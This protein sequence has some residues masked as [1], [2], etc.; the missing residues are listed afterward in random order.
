METQTINN[1]DA[2]NRTGEQ[3]TE[4]VIVK[5][6][7]AEYGIEETKAA[8]IE[9]AFKPMLAKMTDL[10]KEYNLIVNAEMKPQLC[11][12]AKT[13]RLKYVKVRTGTATIHKEMK[14]FYLAGS[15]FVDG[16]KTAQI[17]ASNGI[18]QK[19]LVIEKHFETLEAIRVEELEIKRAA[20]LQPYLEEGKPLPDFLGQ[21]T[22][23]IYNN[24]LLGTKTNHETRIEAERVAEGQRIIKEN[25]EIEER[26]RIKKENAKLKLEAQEKEKIRI[27]EIEKRNEENR[28][29][30]KQQQNEQAARD[31]QARIKEQEYEVELQKQREEKEK[32]ALELKQ[33][34]DAEN[35]IKLDLENKQQAELNQNDAGKL[36]DLQGSLSTIRT[37]YEFE[38]LANRV[39]FSNVIQDISKIINYIKAGG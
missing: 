4:N 11:L 5:V 16:W 25:E 23:S 22:D 21:M 39:M 28:L 24:F 31:E 27:A 35:K 18:E 3:I 12:I 20:E 37:K 19:L 29:L 1:R 15:R 14:A 7:A 9:Q 2:G 33:N 13:L 36:M 26:E 38:S 17:F 10:E 30:L 8:E 6:N 34:Q 32:I